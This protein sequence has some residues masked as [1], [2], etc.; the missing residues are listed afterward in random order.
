MKYRYTL[1]YIAL[2]VLVNYGFAKVPPIEISAGVL[3]PPVSLLVGFV[4]VVRDFSQREIGHYVLGAMLVGAGLSWFMA[5]PT[6]AIASA[7]A[8]LVGELVDWLVY[9]FTRRPLSERIL[10]SS[11]LGTPVDSVVFLGMI[12]FLSPIAAIIQTLSKI[13]GAFIV[14]WLIRR[15]EQVPA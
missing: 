13:L 12:G 15:R 14:W 7:T 8:F 2:I 5:G 9:T 11:I 10:Y 3:W 4:F 1:L 6:I